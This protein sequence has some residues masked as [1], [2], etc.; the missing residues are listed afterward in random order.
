M[1]DAFM[2]T[3]NTPH[4]LYNQERNFHLYTYMYYILHIYVYVLHICFYN[5]YTHIL[6]FNCFEKQELLIRLL[7][8][9]ALTPCSHFITRNVDTFVFEEVCMSSRQ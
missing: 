1:L 7:C 9:F 4:K 6:R 8:H 2:G 3:T 5:I